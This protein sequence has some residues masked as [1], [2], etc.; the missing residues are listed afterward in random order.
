[1]FNVLIYASMELLSFIRLSVVLLRKLGFSSLHQ[2]AFVLEK[3][4]VG[5][6]TRLVFWTIYM[7]QR[8]LVHFGTDTIRSCGR[9]LAD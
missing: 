2:L 9:T 7:V 8:S 3:N 6:Q 4:W 1:M 5:V